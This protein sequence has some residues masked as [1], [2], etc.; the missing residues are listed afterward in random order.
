MNVS[1][2]LHVLYKYR[3]C[4]NEQ[5]IEYNNVID[6]NVCNDT[7]GYILVCAVLRNVLSPQDLL[8]IR[9]SVYSEL[10][11]RNDY[12]E[13]QSPLQVESRAVQFVLSLRVV[14]H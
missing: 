5:T 11:D 13:L 6:R 3:V 7:Y 4:H 8:K 10:S 14:Q 2:T 1:R 12:E 9:H